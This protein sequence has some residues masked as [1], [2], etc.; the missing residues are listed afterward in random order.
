VPDVFA[1]TDWTASQLGRVSKVVG[2]P[3]LEGHTMMFH[4]HK[5]PATYG[6]LI[7][8]D[9][10][11]DAIS[12]LT[13]RDSRQGLQILETQQRILRFLVDCCKTIMHD[14]APD[15]L[16]SNEY[17]MQP[18]VVLPK[19]T[20]EGFAS[21]AIMTSETPY[22]V[23]AD[24]DLERLES[25]MEAQT[26]DIEDHL[27]S[28]REDPEY[29]A[30]CIPDRKDHSIQL[31]KDTNGHDHPLLEPSLIVKLWCN[32]IITVVTGAHYRLES[33]TE[34][35][36]QVKY[37]RVLHA[38]HAN[39]IS[40]TNDLPEEYSDALLKFSHYLL[41]EATTHSTELSLNF[42]P[43]PPVRQ[44]FVRLPREADSHHD[45]MQQR[46]DAQE[47]LD[48]VQKQLVAL[49]GAIG[50]DDSKIV[51][52]LGLPG[53]VDELERLVQSEPKVRRTLNNIVSMCGD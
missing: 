13:G 3:G 26:Y 27:W 50:T 4:N 28:L 14:V 17:L 11:V 47:K 1:I 15:V 2:G 29:F 24:M 40:R 51:R 44:F 9:D 38:K 39:N 52:L 31:L 19:E 41:G 37:L 10:D 34:L 49:L 42:Y 20:A 8:D 36:A 21:L 7:P 5:T 12:R 35:L 46:E 23:P 33:W 45:T 6:E 25:I 48:S 22:R 18:A 43:S 32:V 16:T 53:A 30:S